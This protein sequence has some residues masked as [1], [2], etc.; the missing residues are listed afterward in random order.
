[1]DKLEQYRKVI[2]ALL[3][4]YASYK[5]LNPEIEREFICDTIQDRYLVVSFGW[6][7]SRYIHSCSVHMEIRNGKIWIQYNMTDTD[8]AE[9]L[10]ELGVPKTDI[11]LGFHSPFK[12]QFTEYAVS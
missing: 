10:V 5:S 6:E 7:K 9:E 1:M 12:R 11:V 4:E 8:F 3:T 2:Q